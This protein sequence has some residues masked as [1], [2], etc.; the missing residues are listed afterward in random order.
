[1]ANL[2]GK[3]PRCSRCGGRLFL[4]SEYQGRRLNY[5]WECSV[6]C[7][8]QFRL[9]GTPVAYRAGESRVAVPAELILAVVR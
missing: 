2:S 6:G 7:S 4:S 8:R 5:F 1:M 3:S 9:D